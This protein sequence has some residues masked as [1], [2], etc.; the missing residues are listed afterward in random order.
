[1]TNFD[2][3]T[4]PTNAAIPFGAYGTTGDPAT[5]TRVRT[6]ERA[7]LVAWLRSRSE[8]VDRVATPTGPY[9]SHIY[10]T[11]ADMIERGEDR[12]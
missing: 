7:H 12:P 3:L 2:P 11:I 8:F 10:L 4:W 6:E 5:E 1:M 9:R